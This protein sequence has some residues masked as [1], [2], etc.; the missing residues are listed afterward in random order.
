MRAWEQ[1]FDADDGKR[2]GG[3]GDGG[4][5]DGDGGGRAGYREHR[6]KDTTSSSVTAVSSSS[7]RVDPLRKASLQVFGPKNE[8]DTEPWVAGYKR[9]AWLR[10]VFDETVPVQ[11][12]ALL[13]MQDRV[14]F[15]AFLWAGLVA[16]GLTVVSLFIPGGGMSL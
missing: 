14:V 1:E 5:G 8:F 15:S 13:M 4:T 16:T 3:A 7:S 11:S 6:R 12:K 10:K 2:D 9:K